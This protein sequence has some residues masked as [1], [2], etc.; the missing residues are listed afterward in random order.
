MSSGTVGG[1]EIKFRG[2]V[3]FDR[4]VPILENVIYRI[5][6]EG[7]ANACQHSRSKKVL[8]E[9]V[10]DSDNVRIKIHDW[11]IGFDPEKAHE[12]HYG[13]DGIRERARLLGGTATVSSALGQGACILVGLPLVPRE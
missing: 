7:L 10:Q 3:E 6:Q 12:G 13:L 11:G 9:L 8:V 5:V 2:E 4:L 1:P